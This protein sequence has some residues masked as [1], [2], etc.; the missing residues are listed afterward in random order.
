MGSEMLANTIALREHLVGWRNTDGGWGYV[1]G[2]K[3]RL[4]PTCLVTLCDAGHRRIDALEGWTSDRGLFVDGSGVPANV[5]FNGLALFT[6]MLCGGSAKG[7]SRLAA[8]LEQ[9]FGSTAE[10]S[11]FIEQDN[12]LRGWPWVGENFSWTEPTAWCLFA[13]KTW[14]RRSKPPVEMRRLD[15]RVDEAER[16]LFDRAC[17]GGGWNYG[18]RKV[19]GDNL[20]PFVP[21]TALA[22]LALQDRADHASVRAALDWLRRHQASERAT[23][24]LA[25]AC[26]ALSAYGVKAQMA[27]EALASTLPLTLRRQ[28]VAAT[29]LAVLASSALE[30]SGTSGIWRL[31]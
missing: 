1:A 12:S 15:A 10:D 22:L 16:L 24:A 5:A 27:S 26:I 2:G 3:S 20:D 25:W 9:L 31:S 18:N 8:A 28:D 21:T 7:I 6:L 30:P 4:E 14:K 23:Y 19:F 13:L 11:E 29:A 17:A